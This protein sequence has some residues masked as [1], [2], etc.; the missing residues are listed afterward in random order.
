M[1]TLAHFRPIEDNEKNK[2]PPTTEPLNSRTNKLLCECTS[3]S[4]WWSGFWSACGNLRDFYSFQLLSVCMTWTGMTRSLGMSC[5]RSVCLVALTSSSCYFFYFFY[6]CKANP[7]DWISVLYLGLFPCLQQ[8]PTNQYTAVAQY[9]LQG[10]AQSWISKSMRRLW[11]WAVND[12]IS[13]LNCRMIYPR[14]FIIL[15]M[16]FL[17]VIWCHSVKPLWFG[18]H[19]VTCNWPKLLVKWLRHM[20]CF[21]HNSRATRASLIPTKHVIPSTVCVLFL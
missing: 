10:A 17:C 8:G 19:C 14:L 21:A 7:S 12:G 15:S 3:G 5:C 4:G 2:N 6:F 20:F 1:R 16:G 13:H 11:P 18:W 9:L